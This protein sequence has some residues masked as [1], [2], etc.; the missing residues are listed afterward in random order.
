[1]VD[2]TLTTV[3]GNTLMENL[4]WMNV[5]PAGLAITIFLGGMLMMFTN[6][7]TTKRK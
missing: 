5:L 4:D 2:L 7:W 1:M 6:I 3:R